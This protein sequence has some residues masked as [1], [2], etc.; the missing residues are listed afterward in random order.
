MKRILFTLTMAGV[1]CAASAQ[2]RPS[3]MQQLKDRLVRSG[4]V[5]AVPTQEAVVTGDELPLKQTSKVLAPF[6][7]GVGKTSLTQVTI[8]ETTYDLQ[9]NGSI[10]NRIYKK[11]G[12]I[13][14]I[15][16]SWTFSLDQNVSPTYADRG[17]G[18]NFFDG[19]NWMASPISRIETDRRGWPSLLS[20]DNGSEVVVS[21]AALAVPTAIN[22]R[23]LSGS[24]SWT[25][26][27]IPAF[28]TGENTLWA[29]TAAGGPD[30]NT[31]HMIDITYPTGNGGAVV[32]GLDGC[33]TY[34]RSLDG[35]ANWDI[36]RVQP[37]AMTSLE[38]N[39]FRADGYAIDAR[40]NTVAFVA[41][42]ITDDWALWKSTDNGATWTHTIIL[43][44]PFT[45]YDGTTMIT[46]VDGDGIA[47]TLT[48]TDG[49][50]ALVIDNNDVVHCFAGAMLV[51][52]DDPA[53]NTGLFLSTDGLFY[54]NDAMAPGS[55]PVVIA[56]APDMDGDG[57]ASN[58]GADLGGR[59][60][61]I[62]IC[63]QPSAG[64]D[65]N[66]NLYLSYAPL[67]E[68]T[69]S[70]NPSPLD[71]S[72]RN[73]YLM[74]S[75]DGGNTWGTPINVSNSSFD[76]GVFCAV[77]RNV[78]NCVSMIWQQDGS[79]GYAVPPNGEHA[80]GQNFIIYDCVDVTLLLGLN[81]PGGING[82]SISLHPNP[83]SSALMVNYQADKAMTITVVVR[84]ILGQVMDQIT[85]EIPG[86]GN[87]QIVI[88]VEKYAGGVYS[89]ST[90]I[91]GQTATSKFIRQ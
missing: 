38:Y 84:N 52:D 26:V 83:V 68:G 66:N 34:S 11:T 23:P 45:K 56:K 50:Y 16:A 90:L 8:G 28:P 61:N 51:L 1:V 29:R 17:T 3:S 35:G 75:N 53:T 14:S 86:S 43:D 71:F 58:F 65:A 85:K 49:A 76:E 88:P 62:G 24:G 32:N 55:S 19:V 81:Q 91:D 72:Y 21:H 77:A 13:G 30:G 27:A 78:D 18:Y 57:I 6:A 41:G 82:L 20:L 37:P 25:Q 89:V 70:G 87:H 44:F 59:Y 74:A 22:T 42:N 80:V 60:G 47:D 46:D 69:S 12:A 4:H 40:N 67:I 79:P 63:S 36:Q 15:G 9:T 10:Q 54:W 5:T 73:I 64:V 2:N 48:S 33:F 7:S 31:V 39:G